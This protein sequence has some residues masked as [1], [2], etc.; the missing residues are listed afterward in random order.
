VSLGLGGVGLLGL[1]VID[2]LL[3]IYMHPYH[4]NDAVEQSPRFSRSRHDEPRDESCDFL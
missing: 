4:G 3:V 2:D 1:E